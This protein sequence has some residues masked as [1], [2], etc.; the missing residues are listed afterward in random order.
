MRSAQ[1]IL[2]GH[3][4][5]KFQHFRAHD[6]IIKWKP[7]S[8]LLAIC[9]ENS[10]VPGEFPTQRPVTQSFDFYFDLRLNNWLFKQLWG[11]WFE[12]LLCPLWHHGN[13]TENVMPAAAICH[14]YHA[15]IISCH[16]HTIDVG[17]S[18]LSHHHPKLINH[19]MYFTAW[20][21]C[22]S[23]SSEVLYFN[24]NFPEVYSRKLKI[25][26]HICLAQP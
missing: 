1:P 20:W 26:Q 4:F 2:S 16:C 19:K 5:N 21:F 12:T 24:S 6:D 17:S 13:V 3:K 23:N 14:T 18:Y 15:T 10:P 7:L 11:W 22:E 9:A 8:A 25:C